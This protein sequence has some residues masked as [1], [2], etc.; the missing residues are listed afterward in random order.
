MATK[1]ITLA[2]AL[3]AI[4]L[5]PITAR[6]HEG[7]DASASLDYIPESPKAFEGLGLTEQLGAKLPLDVAFRDQDGKDVVLGDYFK[8]DLPVILTFNYSDCPMLCSLQLN[9]L[10]QGLA[11]L[12]YEPSKQFKIVTIDL[13]PRESVS[14]AHETR[15]KY[16]DRLPAAKRAAAARG[17][18]FLTARV[19]GD[20]SGIQRVADAVGFHYKY[21]PER[22]EYAHPAALIFVSSRGTVSRYVGG[23]DYEPDVL[24]ASVIIAGTSETAT[25]AGFVFNC[26]HYEPGGHPRVAMVVLRI[27]AVAFLVLFLAAF[28]VWRLVRRS[29]S[30][31]PG[32]VRS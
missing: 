16:L 27:G 11:Q 21:I 14:R 22:A 5:A 12:D 17:W 20:A 3:G 26:F 28:G 25:S 15:Q 10:A 7:N 4:A 19:P 30:N 13:E 23:T 1:S 18:S 9:G 32:V 29:R 2:V 8:D 6:A 31:H 24:H